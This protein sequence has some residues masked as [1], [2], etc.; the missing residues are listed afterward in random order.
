M[1]K[2]A[3]LV[4]LGLWPLGMA[5]ADEPR[6]PS[7]KELVAALQK[8]GYV[9]FIRHPSTNP[10]QADT[11]PLNLDNTKAQRQL[12]EEGRKQAKA[13]GEAFRTLKVPVD[14]VIASKFQRAAEAAKLLDV[15][16]VETS[17]DVTEGGLVVSPNENKRR[18]QALAKLLAAAPPDGKNTVIVSHRPNLQDAAGKEFGDL[19]EAEVVIFQP[20]G[21]KGF[22]LVRRVGSP[23]VW[24]EWARR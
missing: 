17:T 5:H 21:E 3:I 15:G 6:Q 19:G 1:K 9:L 12:S 13:L 8:G 16:P 20:L 11:D 7:D 18:A 2:Y 23:A 14:K 10:D 24:A 4:L 22:K